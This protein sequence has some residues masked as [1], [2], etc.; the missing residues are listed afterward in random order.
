[1]TLIKKLLLA[2]A[3]L[4]LL[5]L[6]GAIW[7]AVSFDPNQ[8]R[9]LAIDWMREHHQRTLAIGDVKLGMFPR[10]QLELRQVALSEF[11]QP[12]QRFVG[13]E[14]ARLSVQLLPLL[15]K[16]LVIDQIEARGLTLR[17]S[18]DAQGLRNIDDLL[19][20]EP[21]TGDNQVAPPRSAPQ[22]QAQP[23]MFD[24]SGVSLHDLQLQIDDQM[25]HL[26]GQV[27]LTSLGTGRFSPD[28]LTPVQLAAQVQLSEPALA[29]QLSGALQ[30]QIDPGDPDP[31]GGQTQL[32]LA[33]HKVDLNL[34]LQMGALQLKDSVLRL[35]R[36]D[37]QPATELLTLEQL[38]LQLHGALQAGAQPFK[39]ELK[40]PQLAV[41]GQRLQGSA[42]SGGFDLQGPA[43][44][45]GSLSSGAPTGSFAAI[46]VPALK[47]TLGAQTGGAGASRVNGIIQADLSAVLKSRQVTLD[48]LTIDAT[49]QNPALKPLK[50][51][52]GGRVDLTPHLSR[53]QLAGQMNAQAFNTDGQL[54][55]GGAVPLLQAQ[56]RFGELDLDA[57]LP[58][59]PARPAGAASAPE[60]PADAPIDL[61]ALRS[62]DAKI[63]LQAGTLKHQPFVVRDL[64]ASVMLE[65]GRLLAPLGF[66]TWDGTVDASLMADA[67]KAAE[68]QRLGLQATAQNILIQ[69]ALQDL[70]QN[71]LLEGRGQLKLDLRSAGASV[72]AL[73]AALNGTAT[74]QLRDGAIKGINLAQKLRETRAVLSLDKDATSNAS[75]TEKTDFSELKASFAV[76]NGVADNRDLDV[77]SPFLRMTG[78]GQVDLPRSL[79]DYTV[80]TTVAST[81]KGQG[82]AEASAVKGLTV[83]VRLAGPFDAPG[84]KIVWT[85]VAIGPA[86]SSLRQ[87]GQDLKAR[88]GEQLQAKGADLKAKAAEK[89]GIQPGAAASAPVREQVKEKARE[90]LLKG[91]LGK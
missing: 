18:R 75:K 69:G 19:R 13:L 32:R 7:L 46:K 34:G 51:D 66:K 5:V 44:L 78:A 57:L 22:S 20:S 89:L 8:A 91:L 86:D 68:Q 67:G 72:N 90:A 49:V 38:D 48:A 30:L 40:W 24:I 3:G 29:A 12:E 2:A 43:A 79:I 36:F 37:L 47:L 35:E 55:L 64:V 88:A 84:W 27:T 61:A 33:A 9:S 16:Q 56:A 65:G 53:W 14:S 21:R 54:V 62:L 70:A 58:P 85:E 41:Q 63:S 81:V 17:Y 83:P 74:L 60:Q 87:A 59:R 1:M 71:D 77:K 6:A 50:V 76:S 15:R 31:A 4:L 11:R 52:A 45:Q 25:G 28:V 39:A 10:L 23:L 80:R 26:R 73:K 42:L 82:G